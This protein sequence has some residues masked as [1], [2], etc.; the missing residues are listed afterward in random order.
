MKFKKKAG[1]QGEIPTAS[2]PDIV[3]LLLI[4]FMVTT[5]FR[6]SSG[7]PIELPTAKKL[8]KLEAKKNAISIWARSAD[9]ITIDDKQVHVKDI[10]KIMYQKRVENSRLIVSLKFDRN[11]YMGVVSDI[12]EQLREVEALKVNYC[13][14]YGD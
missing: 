2:M 12:Q 4:F 7:L 10:A 8:E 13:A 3:F 6:Q 11:V 14:K 9:E 1:A 5:T